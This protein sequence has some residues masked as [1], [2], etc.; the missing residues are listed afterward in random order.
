MGTGGWVH[1]WG[2]LGFGVSGETGSVGAGGWVR[3][4]EWLGFGVGGVLG[5]LREVLLGLGGLGCA[6]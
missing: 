6:G 1:A 5:L 3:A 4:W 2:W